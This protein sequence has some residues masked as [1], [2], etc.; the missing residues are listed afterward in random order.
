M[1]VK[2][3]S[4]LL[5]MLVALVMVFT[6]AVG[7]FAADE[8]TTQGSKNAIET[9]GKVTK[10]K[11]SF[12]ISA[13]GTVKYKINNG[14]WKTAK[15]TS[16]KGIKEG[17]LVTF[18]TGD[19]TSYRWAKSVK[20]TKCKKNNLKWKKVKGAKYYLVKITKKG[21]KVVYKKVKGTKLKKGVPKGAK[22]QVRPLKV[23]GGKVYVGV[24]CK[25]KKV[26]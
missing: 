11:A 19:K 22:V 10:G 13:S 17:K 9:V 18:K 20:I 15:S 24:L 25:K 16:I 6:S 5:A 14:K 1:G 4:R 23:K 7:I 8:S 26:K 3:K 21:G 2:T 12:K